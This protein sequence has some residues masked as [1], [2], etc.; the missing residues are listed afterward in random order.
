[1]HSKYDNI[2]KN[3]MFYALICIHN[4]IIPSINCELSV[5]NKVWCQELQEKLRSLI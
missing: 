4:H 5:I 2:Y 1:M 3:R